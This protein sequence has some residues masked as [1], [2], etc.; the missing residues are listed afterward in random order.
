MLPSKFTQLDD[1]TARWLSALTPASVH[2]QADLSCTGTA[3]TQIVC[4]WIEKTELVTKKKKK[5]PDGMEGTRCRDERRPRA[6]VAH[7]SVDR[8][9]GSPETGGDRGHPC[10]RG[11]RKHE[12]E[13]S[14]RAWDGER[15]GRRGGGA[16]RAATRFFRQPHVSILRGLNDGVVL[17]R[18]HLF[19]K[20][21]SQG[22]SAYRIALCMPLTIW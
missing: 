9:D 15:R 7:S 2:K 16:R 1:K 12:P 17:L 3:C 6:H 13:S 21:K 5:K 4:A 11:R 10:Q 8:L 20:S 14:P 19:A 22:A 18:F